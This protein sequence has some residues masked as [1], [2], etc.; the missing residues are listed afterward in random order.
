M[1]AA[2][3]GQR[4]RQRPPHRLQQHPHPDAAA[5]AA[6]ETACASTAAASAAAP[7]AASPLQPQR[8]GVPAAAA[9]AALPPLL[10][11]LP[12][13]AAGVRRH[14]SQ[15]PLAALGW[16]AGRGNHRAC[17][18]ARRGDEQGVT[19]GSKGKGGARPPPARSRKRAGTRLVRR[20]LATAHRQLGQE[21][22]P[23][24]SWN[25]RL[26]RMQVLQSAGGEG[27]GGG[28]GA[29]RAVAAQVDLQESKGGGRG[30]IQQ[31]DG[32]HTH[33]SGRSS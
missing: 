9:A 31:G 3:T 24:R 15:A 14:T 5:A 1:C 27:G 26:G 22:G 28:A 6:A 29:G 12:L 10:P 13:A 30:T 21:G 8:L 33:R 23:L 11:L 19:S 17:C 16:A 4:H 2:V 7:A 20:R 25:S 32:V 18:R